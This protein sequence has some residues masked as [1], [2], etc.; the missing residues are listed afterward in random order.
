MALKVYSY[1]P[2]KSDTVVYNM[3]GNSFLEGYAV[4]N[5][6]WFSEKYPPA[7]WRNAAGIWRIKGHKTKNQK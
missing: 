3:A 1:Q 4:V 7:N 2:L 6:P 5:L